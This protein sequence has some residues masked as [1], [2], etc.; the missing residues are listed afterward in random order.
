MCAP[1]HGQ[2]YGSF[3]FL[4]VTPKVTRPQ[5]QPRRTLG[6]VGCKRTL[7]LGLS[8]CSDRGGCVRRA[9]RFLAWQ[10]NLSCSRKLWTMRMRV[11][12]R[13]RALLGGKAL[14]AALVS[15][16][17]GAQQTRPRCHRRCLSFHDGIRLCRKQGRAQQLWQRRSRRRRVQH[18]PQ[19][20]GR[21]EETR[22]PRRWLNHI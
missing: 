4:A 14:M 12:A 5:L 11:S 19:A 18:R 15:R 16:Q 6:R 1:R 3:S 20:T 22:P 10:L 8:S 13:P 21:G 7:M 9:C 2:L 17:P